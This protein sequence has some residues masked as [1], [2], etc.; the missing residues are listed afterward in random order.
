MQQNIISVTIIDTNRNNPTPEFL[1]VTTEDQLENKIKHYM[2]SNHHTGP[3]LFVTINNK[4]HSTTYEATTREQLYLGNQPITKLPSDDYDFITVAFNIILQNGYEDITLYCQNKE[5][6]ITAS[7][8]NLY[9]NETLSLNINAI[10]T[11]IVKTQNHTRQHITF[12]IENPDNNNPIQ[13]EKFPLITKTSI[14][15]IK[16]LETTTKLAS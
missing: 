12:K 7:I 16:Q 5:L 1:C 6:N 9:E 13:I 8:N 3:I 2:Q 15:S 10:L 14:T 11:N 4:G